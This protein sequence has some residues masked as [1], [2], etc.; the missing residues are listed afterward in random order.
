MNK[1]SINKFAILVILMI[2][3]PEAIG[4]TLFEWT[5]SP[6][7]SVNAAVAFTENLRDTS[8]KNGVCHLTL[9]SDQS[10]A[11]IARATG[12]QGKYGDLSCT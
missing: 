7:S 9:E 4:H 12:L 1:K 10:G 8:D 3:V 2:A 5:H 6:D 11:N